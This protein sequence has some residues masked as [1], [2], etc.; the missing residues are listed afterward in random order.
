[1]TEEKKKSNIIL[2]GMPGCGKSSFGRRLAEALGRPF[3]DADD[4][5]VEREHRTI[6]DLFDEGEDAFRDAEIRT[7]CYLSGGNGL[8]IACGGGV[9]E[10]EENIRLYRK[11]GTIIF[12]D[13]SPEAI[14]G[15]VE[16]GGRPLLKEGKQRVLDLYSRRIGKY[17]AAADYT[18]KNDG[19]EEQV[20]EKLLRLVKEEKL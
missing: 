16:T 11:T 18:V 6:K 20:Q 13:R 7:S 3:R 15:D 5:L 9:V 4:V 19:T 12:L 17:R 1:M 14:M 8:V 2:I 10:R